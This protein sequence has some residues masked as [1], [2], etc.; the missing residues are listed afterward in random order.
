MSGV[1]QFL[2][3]N[4][5]NRTA[6]HVGLVNNMPDAAMRATELQFA[7]LL[8]DAAGNLDVRLRLF[9]LRSIARDEQAR[10]RMAGFYDDA[11][12]LQAANIDALIVTG[13]GPVADDLR[14]EP[15]RK[16]LAALI[17]WAGMGTVSTLFSNS[18]AHAAI[19][20]MDGIACR[21]LPAK[22]S[23][24]YGSARVEDDPL[25]FNT[26]AI[27]PVPHSRR[28]DVAESDLLAR[29]Y[30]VLARLDS[31]DGGAVDIFTR[32]PPGYSRFVFLQGHP[33]YDPGTLGREYLR[34]IGRF[35]QG[36][37]DERPSVPE[38]YFDR[39]TENRLA[40]IADKSDLSLYREVVLGALPR[41]IWRSNTVRLFSNWLLL[42]AATKARRAASKTVSTRRRAS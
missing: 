12:F 14:N 8:K 40:G 1:E 34:D 9:S 38:H 42:V 17:D 15:Y 41:Q 37:T 21:P 19:L 24:I 5:H 11:A 25:F 4:G 10:S 28:N 27:A 35:L 22:L 7:R 13:A 32:E 20:H 16:E 18:A 23:G 29:G 30:R 2:L 33:E 31:K 26:A 6:I 39:A 36:E 3:G